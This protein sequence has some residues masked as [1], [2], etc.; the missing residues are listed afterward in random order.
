LVGTFINNNH[1]FIPVPS[2]ST[3]HAFF[4]KKEKNTLRFP[5]SGS[6]TGRQFN[7]TRNVFRQSDWWI[8]LKQC[9]DPFANVGGTGN[10]IDRFD[11]L[12]K[13]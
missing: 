2:I 10:L 13:E 3:P 12:L 5:P 8:Q 1:A 6:F 11:L 9:E 7:S 4:S